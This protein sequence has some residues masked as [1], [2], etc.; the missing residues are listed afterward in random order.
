M[1][2]K[3][4]LLVLFVII[5][6][7]DLFAVKE[8]KVTTNNVE[9]IPV[10]EGVRDIFYHDQYFYL[11]NLFDKKILVYDKKW[12]LVQ[13]IGRKGEGPSEFLNP[14]QINIYDDQIYVLDK[15]LNEIKIFSISGDFMKSTKLQDIFQPT[16]FILSEDKYFVTNFNFRDDRLLS[17]YNLEGELENKQIDK[18]KEK[19]HLSSLVNN[20]VFIEKM[21]KDIAIFPLKKT[22]ISF[23]SPLTEKSDNYT[24][25]IPFEI[26]NLKYTKKLW[27]KRKDL[28]LGTTVFNDA[29][30]LNEKIF[31]I[32]GG[33]SFPENDKKAA[34]VAFY[35]AIIENGNS[36]FYLLDRELYS[37]QDLSLIRITGN[38]NKLFLSSLNWDFLIQIS[39]SSLKNLE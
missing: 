8:K 28:Y 32:L 11:I 16:S 21:A 5:I 1:S 22:T 34:T 31:A 14:C 36:Q 4:K 12:S 24:L 37:G 3:I 2:H 6:G 35:L 25:E 23:Y 38:E 9:F 7:I 19:N 15:Q 13:T 17:I 26:A 33:G 10:S 39:I 30:L 29:L 18:H 20:T 27:G